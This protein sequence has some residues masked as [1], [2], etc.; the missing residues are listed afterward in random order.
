M[1][2]PVF[3]LYFSIL[4]FGFV[5][6]EKKLCNC[7]LIVW[8][9]RSKVSNN[10]VPW[11]AVLRENKK[12]LCGSFIINDRLLITSASCVFNKTN[13][14]RL[15]VITGTFDLSK[16]KK[17]DVHQ[18]ES[19]KV[20]PLFNGT[21]GEH[22]IGLVRLKKAIKLKKNRTESSCLE[23]SYNN[24][25]FNDQLLLVGYGSNWTTNH[26]TPKY[27]HLII[28]EQMPI[29]SKL[30]HGSLIDGSVCNGEL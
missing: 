28:S 19:I 22:D 26:N 20:H 30:M 8:N 11:M 12:L 24:G 25:Y 7:R 18:I 23:L 1:K 14:N 2:K 10:H 15:D 4:I 13:V 3:A 9:E 17:K 27:S 5:S 21:L 6:A 16:A 29:E